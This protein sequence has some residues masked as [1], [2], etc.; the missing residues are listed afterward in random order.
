MANKNTVYIQSI[1]S[2]DSSGFL[3]NH[4]LFKSLVSI[5]ELNLAVGDSKEML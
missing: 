4:D 5:F 1:C 3:G 2:I